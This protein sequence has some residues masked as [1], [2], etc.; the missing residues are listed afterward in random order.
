[1]CHLLK[2]TG[3]QEVILEKTRRHIQMFA[4][5]SGANVKSR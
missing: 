3:N 5:L 2:K 1:M 4:Y